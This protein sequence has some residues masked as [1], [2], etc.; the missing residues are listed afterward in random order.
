MSSLTRIQLSKNRAYVAVRVV[1]VIGFSL[2]IYALQP[3]TIDSF[4]S[5][6]DIAIAGIV[7]LL[8]T[9][10]VGITVLIKPIK[11][12][13]PFVVLAADW[14]L[15]AAYVYTNAELNPLLLFA[16]AGIT[17]ASGTLR[18]GAVFSVIETIGGSIAFFAALYFAPTDGFGIIKDS[19]STYA[20]GAT[21]MLVMTLL[22]ILWHN[23][24][25]EENS[26]ARQQI[27]VEVEESRTRLDNMRGRAKAF[28]EMATR[29]NETLSYDRILD[30]ALDVGRLSVR[31]DEQQ[32]IVSI[33]L[34]I[35]DDDKMVIASERG[36][37]H[38]DLNHSF[39]GYSGIIAQA[40]DEGVPILTNSS[41]S[42]PELG[43]IHAFD[44]IQTTLCI[45]L[46]A[47][48]ETYGVLVFGST[49]QNA[50]HEDHIDTLEAIGVQTAIALRNAVLYSNLREEKE[51]IIQIEANSRQALVRDL[52]DI[53]TQTIS[54]V[55]MHLSTLPIIS[56]RKPETLLDEIENIRQMA[57]R[58]TEEIR[59]VM[60]TLRPLA[61][62]TQGLTTALNQ[63]AE[64]MEKTYKQP[65]QIKVDPRVE[66]VLKKDAH[67]TLFYL[68]EEAANNARK[69]AQASMILV[70]GTVENKAVVIRIR[71]NGK[72]F[73]TGAV[74]SNYESRGSF[75]MVNMRERAE[76][77]N[78]MFDLQ[79]A[80]G[81][82]TQVT[83][84][85]PIEGKVPA[86]KTSGRAPA[87]KSRNALRKKQYSGPL[88]PGA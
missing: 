15:I 60:F 33:A 51:R 80:P 24:L 56:E 64:K 6:Q 83:V 68:I 53:P 58:A 2:A 9:L 12:Y 19:L 75:G 61:L 88:S 26:V 46:R 48:Y 11:P 37:H 42:D 7:A 65:M 36:L 17:I 78:G 82:G 20:P 77:I 84:R 32:R 49:A 43:K 28:S 57:L 34:M 87:Q 14:A 8:G 3:R 66:Q 38:R 23:S 4:A 62:E 45:P 69:Y 50:I 5:V 41:K 52:H 81:K 1:M 27:Q 54:A 73:D 29:L 31:D 21:L 44:G 39:T 76:L 71:D 63:L 22:A 40:L 72:G 13:V 35:E 25:N 10:I 86:G 59:H 74:D 30:A 55:A 18:M 16:I 70:R 67:G 79:S 47:H 85:V